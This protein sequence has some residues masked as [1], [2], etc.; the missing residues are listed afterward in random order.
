MLHGKDASLEISALHLKPYQELKESLSGFLK[1]LWARVLFPTSQCFSP[2]GCWTCVRVSFARFHYQRD[3]NWRLRGKS[4]IAFPVQ[5]PLFETQPSIR[6]HHLRSCPGLV[7]SRQPSWTTQ[8]GFMPS[9]VLISSF[10]LLFACWT[11]RHWALFNSFKG[12]QGCC[13]CC[14]LCLGMF[15]PEPAAL[16]PSALSSRFLERE[17]LTSFAHRA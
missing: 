13:T 7:S 3:M 2:T 11:A 16:Q 9:S 15:F 8:S 6:R 1:S 4:L 14:S 17:L 10:I 12:L 5:F